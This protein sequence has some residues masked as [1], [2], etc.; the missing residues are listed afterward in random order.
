L[1]WS[2][3]SAC[4]WSSAS[5]ASACRSERHRMRRGARVSCAPR[6]SGLF[7]RADALI[8]RW[9]GASL[10]ASAAHTGYPPGVEPLQ[11]HGGR[12]SVGAR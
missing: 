12:R 10:V 8:S 2:S 5:G 9:T 1:R 3:S 7:A 4:S 6:S 11:F